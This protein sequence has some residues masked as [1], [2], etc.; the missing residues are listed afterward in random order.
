MQVPH[1]LFAV[2]GGNALSDASGNIGVNVSAGVGNLQHNGLAIASA[3]C[4]TCTP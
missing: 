1:D 3:S 4:G 2:L